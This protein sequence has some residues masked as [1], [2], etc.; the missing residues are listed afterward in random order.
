MKEVPQDENI[1]HSNL[2][3]VSMIQSNAE[4]PSYDEDYHDHDHDVKYDLSPPPL[5]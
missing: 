3:I 5:S 4:F 2:D 1:C